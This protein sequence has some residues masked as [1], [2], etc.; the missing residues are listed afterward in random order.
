M[1]IPVSQFLPSSPS[2]LKSMYLFST[3]VSLYSDGLILTPKSNR[4]H[5]QIKYS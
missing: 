1:S 3:S 5:L 4:Y 2:P